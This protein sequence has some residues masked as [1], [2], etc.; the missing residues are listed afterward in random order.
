MLKKREE[1]NE[2]NL[3]K[4]VGWVPG[5]VVVERARIGGREKGKF[6]VAVSPHFWV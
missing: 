6:Q 1:D 5:G 2:M 3:E 4:W